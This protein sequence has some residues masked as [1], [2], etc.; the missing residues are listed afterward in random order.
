MGCAVESRSKPIITKI[1]IVRINKG[2]ANAKN[3]SL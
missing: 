3:N 2:G 1:A